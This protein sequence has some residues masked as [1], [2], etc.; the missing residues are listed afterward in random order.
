MEA[1]NTLSRCSEKHR[2]SC[3]DI[4]QEKL[5]WEPTEKATRKP[6]R[7]KGKKVRPKRVPRLHSNC[8][9]SYQGART[10]YT[11]L[12]LFFDSPRMLLTE[13]TGVAP[14]A[15]T[16]SGQNF[17]PP[18]AR[19]LAIRLPKFTNG[20]Q[21]SCPGN[22]LPPCR[23]VGDL[24]PFLPARL[25][26]SEGPIGGCNRYWHNSIISPILTP[27]ADLHG[28]DSDMCKAR[29]SGSNTKNTNA[30]IRLQCGAGRSY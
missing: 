7:S 20:L 8:V 18:R 13:C 15:H 4:V 6:P 28:G 22:G 24:C 17:S 29:H 3:P 10:P 21:L 11:F 23:A 30:H 9:S 1:T 27:L 25:A 26:W 2:N 12:W 5:Q 16:R 19:V 14:R